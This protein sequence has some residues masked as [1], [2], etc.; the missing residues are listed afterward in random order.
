[1]AVKS[2]A[3]FDPR[4]T[5][6][7]LLLLV[8]KEARYVLVLPPTVN[9]V[10]VDIQLPKDIGL[11]HLAEIGLGILANRFDILKHIGMGK[12]AGASEALGIAE[13]I[14]V[15]Y[16]FREV[17]TFDQGIVIIGHV[18]IV[19]KLLTVFPNANLNTAQNGN[20]ILVFL[21]QQG[22]I[23]EIIPITVTLLSLTEFIRSLG[24]YSI[25]VVT[26]AKQLDTTG[27]G[28]LDHHARV[29]LAANRI[30]GVRM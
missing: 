20:A 1:M 2:D 27:N 16:R 13:Q 24:G 30:I 22:N 28:G 18:G 25:I 21:L 6:D 7:I 17:Q 4:A 26:E 9:T 12:T 15:C 10:V 5:D 23:I 11:C 3:E 14:T 29:I 8:G 19:G